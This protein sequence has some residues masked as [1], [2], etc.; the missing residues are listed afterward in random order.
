MKEFSI[1]VYKGKNIHYIDYSNFCTSKEKTLQLLK[2]SI[3]ECKNSE[4]KSTLTLINVVNL[5]FDM[6]IIN[7]FQDS[8]GETFPYVK[9]LAV[10]GLAGLQKVAYNFII[11]LSQKYL[12]KAFDTELEAKEWL[13]DD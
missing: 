5:S 4:P 2:Y 9:K 11:K 1:I 10:I 3:E 7:A 8:I 6:E 13:T 12:I